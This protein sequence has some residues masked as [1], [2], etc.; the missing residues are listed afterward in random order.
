MEKYS[1]VANMKRDIS[2]FV[3][4][5]LY[6]FFYSPDQVREKLQLP[7]HQNLENL[8]LARQGSISHIE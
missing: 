1:I 3:F 7:Q 8:F 6:N 5:G 4:K 2:L